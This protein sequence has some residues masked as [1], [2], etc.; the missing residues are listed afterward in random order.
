MSTAGGRR[1]QLLY[2][3]SR[4]HKG[5]QRSGVLGEVLELVAALIYPASTL[6]AATEIGRSG[7]RCLIAVAK[8]AL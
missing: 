1:R 8:G 3:V 6:C 4:P 5:S 7:S 2:I